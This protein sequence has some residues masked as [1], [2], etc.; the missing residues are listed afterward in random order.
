ME[1]YGW[2]TVSAAHE[3]RGWGYDLIYGPEV[4]EQVVF[5]ECRCGFAVQEFPGY[6]GDDADFVSAVSGTGFEGLRP[7]HHF[8][9]GFHWE[10]N[11]EFM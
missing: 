4:Q 1:C 6:A 5:G 9:G 10:Y 7:L 8:R 11:L 3:L 2:S